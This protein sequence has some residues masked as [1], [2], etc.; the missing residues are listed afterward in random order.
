MIRKLLTPRS[1]PTGNTTLSFDDALNK[2][3]LANPN[4][5]DADAQTAT[6]GYLHAINQLGQPALVRIPYNTRI[7]SEIKV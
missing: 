1:A 3:K 4:V 6:T 5:S 2:F 7:C